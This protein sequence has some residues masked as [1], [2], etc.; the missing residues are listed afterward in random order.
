[1]NIPKRLCSPVLWIAMLLIAAQSSSGATDAPPLKIGVVYSYTGAPEYIGKGLDAS[2]AAYTALHGDTIAGRKV[3]VVK[4]DDTGIAPDIARRM[5]QELVVQ[6]NVDVLIGA[7]TTPNA[8]A[9]ADVSTQAKKP[10]FIVN[11]GTSGILAKAPYSAR[12]GFTTA[13][14]T[15]PLAKWAYQNGAKSAFLMFQDYGP[16]IDGGAAFRKGF[17]AEGGTVVGEA[18]VPLTNQ[19]YSA[20]VQR[21]RDSKAEALYTFF[22]YIGGSA[23]LKAAASA[24]LLKST[25]IMST[26]GLVPDSQLATSAPDIAL[27][28]ISTQNY[29]F[30]HD[31]KLNRTFVAAFQKAYGSAQVPEFADCAGFDAMNAIYL[32][33]KA[34]NG[35]LD[36]EKTMAAVRGMHFESPRGPLLIDRDTRGAIQNVYVRRAELRNGRIEPV[37]IST[38][39]MVKDP[40]ER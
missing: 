35:S 20:Y 31:S 10:F 39:S 36:P 12:F 22:N 23:M 33:A 16:G 6:E 11:A 4:R 19:D 32:I 17:E 9:I 34:Q 40:N 14:I 24:G 1:M 27:G 5:A 38:I 29:S 28:L 8:I 21:V 37:E 18:R 3:V 15:V 25:K 7:T 26:D 30:T 13:Q 2:I